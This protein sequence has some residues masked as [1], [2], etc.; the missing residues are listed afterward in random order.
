M[1]SPEWFAF[2]GGAFSLRGSFVIGV[3]PALRI[4]R[5]HQMNQKMNVNSPLSRALLGAQSGLLKSRVAFFAGLLLGLLPLSAEDR[6]NVIMLMSDDQGWGDV[7]FNGHPDLKTPH[8]DEMARSG[9]RFDRFYAA[10]PLCSPTRGSCLTGRFPFRF[11]IL[12]AHTGGM[13]PGEVTIAEALKKEGYATGFFGKWHLGWIEHEEAG[14]RGFYSPPSHHGYDDTF[15]T[16]SAVPT[17]D[18]TQTPEGWNT[19]GQRE[20]TPWKDGSAFRENGQVVTENLTGDASRI[21]MDRVMPFLEE[22]REGPFLATV[23]L[24]A[25]H[26]PVVAGPEYLAQYQDVGGKTRQHYYGCLT[27]MDDQIGRLRAKLRELGIE[28][29]TVLF[30]CSDNGPADGLAKK[31]IASS[32]PFK[33][34]KHRMYEG[35]LLVPACVEWPGVIPAGERTSVRCST[36]DFFPTIANLTGFK[37]SS[38]LERPIDGMDLMPVIQGQVKK[39]AQPLFFGFRR[40]HANIDGK[41]L[42]EGDYKLLREAKGESRIRL[43]DIGKDPYE[44]KDLADSKPQLVKELARKLEKI[45]ASCQQSRDGADY[46][47]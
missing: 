29:K 31:G 7:G 40:L 14:S 27:A 16:T 39:R 30:F 25:P 23:W 24:H 43:Y 19:W 22:H 5:P 3:D 17:W 45:E 33:G 47:Y 20:G 37:F 15:A 32:G 28:K 9:V 4:E 42:I 38:S 11:G 44:K 10:A 35:G 46:R 21:V 13:R 26:E 6:P 36:V 41:A 12:A 18:P 34:Y 1:K 8:L 2:K